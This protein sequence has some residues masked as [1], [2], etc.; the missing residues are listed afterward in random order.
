MGRMPIKK[1]KL[2]IAPLRP[3][4]LACFRTWGIRQELA[5]PVRR[6]KNSIFCYKAKFIP[7]GLFALF[8][9]TNTGC[10]SG[11]ELIVKK[12]IFAK[13]SFIHHLV[14]N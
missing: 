2:S 3:P 7:H 13:K 14:C 5:V 10:H 6:C 8:V 12:S 4:T 1:G 11:D 9:N